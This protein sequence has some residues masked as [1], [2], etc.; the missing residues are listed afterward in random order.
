[1]RPH[2]LAAIEVSAAVGIKK[3]RLETVKR[4]AGFR[5]TKFPRFVI[6]LGLTK[7]PDELEEAS[8]LLPSKIKKK[9]PLPER[10]A[11]RATT[12]DDM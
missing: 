3:V 2:I 1:M 7:L 12:K 5:G 10:E 8:R 4:P 11:V 6:A 9:P